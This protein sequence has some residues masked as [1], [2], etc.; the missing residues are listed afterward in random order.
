MGQVSNPIGAMCL[1]IDDRSHEL[2]G[3]F[4]ILN[5]I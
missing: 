1:G 3:G 5:N 4:L 2:I